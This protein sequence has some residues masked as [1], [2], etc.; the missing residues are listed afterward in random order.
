MKFACGQK[1]KPPSMSLQGLGV[2]AAVP[3]QSLASEHPLAM[4][5]GKINQILNEAVSSYVNGQ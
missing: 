1:V 5:E 4:G 3:V 2:T